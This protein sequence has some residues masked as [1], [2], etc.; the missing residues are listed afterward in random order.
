VELPGLS[1]S[2]TF[3]VAGDTLFDENTLTERTQLIP[4]KEPASEPCGRGLTTGSQGRVARVLPSSSSHPG[5][6]GVRAQERLPALTLVHVVGA[7]RLASLRCLLVM[8]GE[9]G[10]NAGPLVV[11]KLREAGAVVAAPETQL[12]IPS[13]VPPPSVAVIKRTKVPRTEQQ[14]SG[15]RRPKPLQHRPAARPQATM[16]AWSR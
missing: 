8:G 11:L 14:G 1:A 5:S 6:W 16:R 3:R 10:R 12:S 15:L 13:T 7:R 4:P 2:C 9:N